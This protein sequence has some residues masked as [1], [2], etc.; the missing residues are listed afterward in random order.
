MVI[1][2]LSVSQLMHSVLSL[3]WLFHEHDEALS[4][5]AHKRY[6][7]IYL[8]NIYFSNGVLPQRFGAY[9]YF[10]GKCGNKDAIET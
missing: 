2:V 1:F 6:S 5:M 10:F 9:F 7:L 3:A 8:F 4:E